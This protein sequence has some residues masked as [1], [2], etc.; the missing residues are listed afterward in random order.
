MLYIETSAKEN[1]G[2]TQVFEEL[3]TK[4]LE[5]PFLME[6]LGMKVQTVEIS[7]TTQQNEEGGCYY[8]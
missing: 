7:S 2:I 8:C 4:I 6:S 3:V 1:I 5:S